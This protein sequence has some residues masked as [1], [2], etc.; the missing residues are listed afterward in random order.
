[1]PTKNLLSEL[2]RQC[3]SEA[4]AS[5]LYASSLYQHLANQMQRIGRFGASAFLAKESLAERGHY[6][7]LV[8]YFNQRGD[9]APMPA[10]D[11]CEDRAADMAQALRIVYETEVQLER[12][13]LRWYQTCGCDVTRQFLLGFIEEQRVS[14]GEVAD[15]IAELDLAGDDRAALSLFDKKLSEA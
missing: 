2:T 6:L 13:Y 5:E 7:K 11:A 8:E 4:A 1:M 14:I 3:L 15:L 12:D 9:M 10:I